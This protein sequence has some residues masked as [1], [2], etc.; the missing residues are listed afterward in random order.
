MQLVINSPGAS[1]RKTGDRFLVQA[2]NKKFPVSAHKVQSILIT[3]GVFLTTDAIE[4]ATANN[5]DLVF[6]DR[7][8][9]PFAR[10]WQARMG[11]TAAIRR[12]QIEA[13]EG[14]E[15]LTLVRQWVQAK[16]RHQ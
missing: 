3:T 13:A 1:L 9:D 2:G 6:L 12:R 15:G 5:I 10:V 4:L 8:G 14:S 7:H 11:S 16:L